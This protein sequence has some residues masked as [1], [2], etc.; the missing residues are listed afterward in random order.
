MGAGGAAPTNARGYRRC[1]LWRGGQSVARHGCG[2]CLV[3]VLV[4]FGLN[5]IQFLGLRGAGKYLAGNFYRE[6]R[7]LGA[8]R[9]SVCTSSLGHDSFRGNPGQQIVPRGVNHEE[10][11]VSAV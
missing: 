11:Y 7:F 8:M 9:W 4:E 2:G 6:L 1:G 3:P 5:W 10:K